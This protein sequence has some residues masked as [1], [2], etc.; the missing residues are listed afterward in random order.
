MCF[1]R[2]L[3]LKVTKEELITLIS[4]EMVEDSLLA[5]APLSY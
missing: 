5:G 1:G 3:K 4:L 2:V